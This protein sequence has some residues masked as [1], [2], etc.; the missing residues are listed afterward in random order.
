MKIIMEGITPNNY[1]NTN[2]KGQSITLS[3]NKIDVSPMESVLMAAASCSS[4]DIELILE[5]MRQKLTSI[6]VEVE[7]TRAETSPKVFTN[8]SLHYILTGENLK[9]DKV[10]KAIDMSVNEYCSVLCMLVKTAKIETTYT[11]IES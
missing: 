10:Q 5:K 9:E 1:K 3:G 6:K 2:E 7:G 11:I 8:I 4:V